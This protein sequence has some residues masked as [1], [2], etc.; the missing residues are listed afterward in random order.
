MRPRITI[1]PFSDT[2]YATQLYSYNGFTDV[3]TTAKP[4]SL[5]FE[6]SVSGA[7][8]FSIEIEDSD[9]TLDPETFIK[10]NRV[11]IEMSKDGST[12]QPAFKGL[13][14]SCTRYLFGA[15]GST[16]TISGFSYLIRFNER[17]LNIIKQSTLTTGQDYNRGDTLMFTNNL[18][19]DLLT[20]DINYVYNIDDTQKYSLFKTAN[21]TSS[22]INDWVPRVDAQLVTVADAINSILE[23]GNG[24]ITIDPSNDQL[25]LFD[26]QQVTSATGVFLVTDQPNLIADNAAYTMYPVE[27]YKYTVSYDYPDSGSRL[28]GSIGS[29]KC[30]ETII[31][32]TPGSG[33]LDTTYL[34]G[35]TSAVSWNGGV[36]WGSYWDGG[37]TPVKRIRI[38]CQSLGAPTGA[39][40]NHFLV[41]LQ[42][43]ING[44]LSATFD[45]YP[46]S[47]TTGYGT[48]AGV[49]PVGASGVLGAKFVITSTTSLNISLSGTSYYVAVSP[50]QTTA[51]DANNNYHWGYDPSSPPQG[52]FVEFNSSG[53]AIGSGSNAD[54]KMEVFAGSGTPPVPTGGTPSTTIPPC[55]GLPQLADADP[56]FAVAEDKNMSARLGVVERSLSDL[57][58]HIR[59]KQS[60][61]EYLFTKLFTASKPRFVFDYPAVTIPNTIPRA[62]DICTH[63]AKKANVGTKRSPLQVGVILSVRYDFNQ[64]DEGVFSLTKMG[65]STTGLRRGY[66]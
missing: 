60:M 58:S 30:P 49:V 43:T 6:G 52:N 10:G 57:P 8:T 66:Y 53:T 64:D 31:P 5:E 33:G 29:V 35:F 17:I 24:I 55:G 18:I 26:P 12:W 27:P 32:G 13:V 1:Y 45:M 36:F 48:S 37:G 34:F 20:T 41:Q 62:G 44:A 51:Q 7:G 9:G 28:V 40:K 19:N 23:F 11:F 22:P 50:D 25:I 16:F 21:I 39:A 3:G 46:E 61:D 38:G 65:L 59:K 42:N 63:V 56:V 54:F 2:T 14:R 15:K 47:V 4:I